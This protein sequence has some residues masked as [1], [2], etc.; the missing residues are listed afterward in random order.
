M[1]NNGSKGLCCIMRRSSGTHVSCR[2][3][4]SWQFPQP[5]EMYCVLT[6]DP[7]PVPSP[8]NLSVLVLWH[9]MMSSQAIRASSRADIALPDTGALAAAEY[10]R[11]S[12]GSMRIILSA[13]PSEQ[14]DASD[15]ARP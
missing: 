12:A 3:T 10:C 15:C 13:L 6:V 1:P 5:A 11:L 14:G 2:Y 7:G 4:A 9:V 8:F